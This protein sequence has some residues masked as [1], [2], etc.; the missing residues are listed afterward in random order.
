MPIHTSQAAGTGGPAAQDNALS[1]S[2]LVVQAH[3]LSNPLDVARELLAALLAKS[4]APRGVLAVTTPEADDHGLTPRILAV[5]DGADDLRTAVERD[6]P[7]PRQDQVR[8]V[9]P[10]GVDEPSGGS[11]KAAGNAIVLLEWQEPLEQ[12]QLARTRATLD[13][14]QEAVAAVVLSVLSA[15]RGAALQRQADERAAALA[16]AYVARGDWEQAFDAVSDPIAVVSADFQVTRVNA[17]YRAMFGRTPAQSLRHACF[18]VHAGTNAPCPGCP[19]PLTIAT[20]SPGFVEQEELVPFGPDHTFKRRL[21]H[22]WTYPVF[23]SSGQVNR[24][25]EIMKDVTEQERLRKLTVQTE[26]L[27]AADQLKAELLGT[28]S[29]EL[30][31]PLAAIKGYASTLLR[32]ERRLPR[33]ERHEFL[34]AI[35]E[36]SK[37]M[38][39]IINH[40]LE[41]SQLE[42]GDA[43]INCF[44][45]DLVPVAREAVAALAAKTEGNKPTPVPLTLT[46]LDEEGHVTEREP[47]IFADA[48]AM[49]DLL[50]NLLENAVKYSPQGGEIAVALR[51]ARGGPNAAASH[52]VI[53]SEELGARVM[54]VLASDEEFLEL[55][56]SDKG[57]G[58]PS[59]HLGR[60]FDRFHRVDTRLTREVD[61]L[62]LGLAICRRLVELHDGAIWAES[63]PGEGSV[64][65]VLLPLAARAIPHTDQKEK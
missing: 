41:L 59:E 30:R 23:D 1:L 29:H 51:P 40:L 55:T 26:E 43:V 52:G 46:L 50:D 25:V 24:V 21:F 9:I 53:P 35:D 38:E 8:L 5:A 2:H 49:R 32:H 15:E 62:G 3:T 36:A 65:H 12:R 11:G 37:R 42:T 16:E 56:V 10:L 20:G 31:S 34:E 39:A 14:L 6:D 7:A 44:A 64:F 27:R 54:S 17:A 61:G 18:T 63:Q 19:L 57:V 60:I 33:V 58:I 45:M 48:R 13:S 47:L 22:V 28:V 4:H